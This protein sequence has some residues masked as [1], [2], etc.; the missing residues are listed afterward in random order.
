MFPGDAQKQMEFS[1][2][3]KSTYYVRK[4]EVERAA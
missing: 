1:G 3:N 4:K 2:L